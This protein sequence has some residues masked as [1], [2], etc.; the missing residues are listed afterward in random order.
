MSKE[1][2]EPLLRFRVP[3]SG[4]FWRDYGAPL[5]MLLA[6]LLCLALVL[7]GL[8]TDSLIVGA[9]FVALSAG[10]VLAG[11]VVYNVAVVALLVARR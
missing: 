8:S 4:G 11:L 9:V 3:V 1:V 7:G 6:M 10:A 5:A 2:E